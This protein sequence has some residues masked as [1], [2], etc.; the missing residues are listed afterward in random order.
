MRYC[1]TVKRSWI[2]E[3]CNLLIDEQIDITWQL[4][5][6]T[7]SEALD[8]EVAELLYI[9]G[10]R[11]LS[12]A[13]ESGSQEVLRTIKKKIDFG[14]MLS[15]MRACVKV[16]MNIKAN[17]ICAFPEENWRHLFESFVSIVKMAWVGCHDLSISIP[18]ILEVNCLMS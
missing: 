1:S 12:Y 5:S 16:G 11:N 18:P 9:S 17:L 13:P 6:G 7:R 3:F 10:C 4:P 2:I 8:M 15:S 14:N